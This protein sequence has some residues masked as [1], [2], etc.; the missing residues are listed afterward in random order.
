[1]RIFYPRHTIL[2]QNSSEKHISLFF[3]NLTTDH[4]YEESVDAKYLD[5][6]DV[7]PN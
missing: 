1:M 3:I 6:K 4:R 5:L 7:F 2:D